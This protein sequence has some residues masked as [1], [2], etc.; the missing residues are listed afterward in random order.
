MPDGTAGCA[1]TSLSARAASASGATGAAL[2]RCISAPT[3]ARTGDGATSAT[4]PASA[5]EDGSAGA[6][7]L[8]PGTAL[9]G[10]GS[11]EASCD[12]TTI[13]LGFI[14]C[15]VVKLLASCCNRDGST[16]NAH[17]ACSTRTRCSSS[18]VACAT[19]ANLSS[20]PWERCF[21]ANRYAPESTNKAAL[22]KVKGRIMLRA[23]PVSAAWRYARAD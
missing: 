6:G 18:R 14:G 13:W 10:A 20:S 2:A 12:S 4:A 9:F 16:S 19:C 5:S 23:F 3:L 15:S 7:W 8:L 11:S 21:T 1:G 22:I 17:C